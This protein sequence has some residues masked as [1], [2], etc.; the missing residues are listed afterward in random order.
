M[1]KTGEFMGAFLVVEN[2]GAANANSMWLCTNATSP[3]VGTTAI[4]FAGLN[5]L[6]DVTAG[7]GLTRS[8]NS[9]ALAA[10]GSGKLLA[11]IGGGTASPVEQT[12]SAILDALLG[13]TDGDIAVR[14]GGVWTAASSLAYSQLPAE[15]QN[16][17]MAF[18][19]SGLPG[20]G[21]AVCV[22]VAQALTLPAN[23]SGAGS[24]G[25][26][27]TQAAV[28]LLAGDV[29]KLTAPSPQDATL[30][31]IGITFVLQKV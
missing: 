5:K 22:P 18:P 11:N 8:G 14:S 10:I 23:F 2:H 31:N 24:G 7:T 3:T 20:D 30:A 28:N 17:T 21:Q 6:N 19:F 29:L 9:L 15:V 12:L 25:V 13:A 4:T 27:S 16:V 1:D 26:L